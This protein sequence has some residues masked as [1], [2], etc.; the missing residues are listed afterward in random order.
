MFVVKI[1]DLITGNFCQRKTYPGLMTDAGLKIL[2]KTSWGEDIFR[3]EK[4]YK[5]NSSFGAMGIG[6]WAR[7]DT[8]WER[9]DKE[10]ENWIIL[11]KFY[12]F[13]K[14]WKPLKY[15]EMRI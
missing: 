2:N 11:P 9:T 3:V 4:W 10:V 15:W 14:W 8:E 12:L 13:F 5:K 1:T 7:V 6:S